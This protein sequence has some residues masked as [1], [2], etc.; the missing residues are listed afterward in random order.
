M[1]TKRAGGAKAHLTSPPKAGL[2][3]LSLIAF[4]VV[5]ALLPWQVSAQQEL[6]HVFSASVV[7]GEGAPPNGSIVT[8]WIGGRRV[9]VVEVRQGRF[10]MVI[11]QH[12]DISFVGEEVSFRLDGRDLRGSGIWKAG[13][14]TELKLAFGSDISSHKIRGR[15]EDEIGQ[16]IEDF[17]NKIVNTLKILLIMVTLVA[18]LLLGLEGFNAGMYS[19]SDATEILLIGLGGFATFV[20]GYRGIELLKESGFLKEDKFSLEDK[21]PVEQ[22]KPTTDFQ[23]GIPNSVLFSVNNPTKNQGVRIQFLGY[24]TVSPPQ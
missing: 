20:I 15:L 6:S 19:T 5:I 18:I 22:F 13:G 9:G 23:N 16:F 14:I 3:A 1:S 8:A 4:A 12:E 11:P 2:A 24:D 7:V 10:R 21:G 17:K